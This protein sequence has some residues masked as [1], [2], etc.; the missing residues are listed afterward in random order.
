M[1]SYILNY[2]TGYLRIRVEGYSPER[3]LNLCCYHGISLWN[4]KPAGNAYEMYIRAGDFR[5]LHSIIRKSRTKV[6]IKEK[7]GLPFLLHRYRKRKIFFAGAA[8]AVLMV[9]FLSTIIWSI[10]IEGNCIRTDEVILE[11]LK[12]KGITY[13]MRRKEVDCGRI[14]KDIRAGYDD[15]IWVSAYVR[16]STLTIKVKENP[17]ITKPVKEAVDVPADIVAEQD[18]VIQKIITRKGTPL[19]HEG[20][21]VEK[22]EVLVSGSVE[23]KNDAGEVTGYQYQKADADITAQW[24]LPYEDVLGAEHMIKEKTGEKRYYPGVELP[25]KICFLGNGKIPYQN[26][27]ILYQKKSI[28]LDK[29]FQLPVSFLM[30]TV[31]EYK[32]RTAEYTK[33]EAQE[34]L[35]QEF[36]R[37]CGQ[38]R[39]KGV[40][41]SEN[42]VKIYRETAQYV[43]KGQLMAAGP[44]GKTVEGEKKELPSEITENKPQEGN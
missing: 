30:K 5:K 31:E 40:Q 35:T 23:V 26:Y 1:L 41:I 27:T 3:F 24:T 2:L 20:S 42:D 25:G 34:I 11:F 22:G 14:V 39:K 15:I 4:L 38:L 36:N 33:K 9:C 29:H 10:R 12:E 8:L 32:S 19:V 44:F 7:I 37:F 28:Y 21:Q 18:G 17:G 13:G 6:V 43:A 16:G